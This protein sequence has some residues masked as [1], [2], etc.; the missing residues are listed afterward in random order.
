MD[1]LI[2]Y[3]SQTIKTQNNTPL[4]DFE[5]YSPNEMNLLLHYPLAISC[6]L[7]ML[8]VDNEIY[9]KIPFFNNVKYLLEQIEVQG[10]LK[11]T[12][13][14]FLPTKVVADIYQ[15]GFIK[16]LMIE[17]GYYKLY[18]ESD[19]L[20]VHLT[21]ILTELS[22]LVKKRNN[23]LSLTKKGQT[24]LKN[25]SDLFRNIFETFTVKFNWSYNDGY[26]NEKVGQMGFAFTFILLEKYGQ[27]F[28]SKDFYSEKYLKAFN[29]K[30]ESSDEDQADYS[31]RAY[32]VRTFERFLDYFG[33]IEYETKREDSK[34]K[35]SKLFSDIFKILPHKSI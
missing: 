22:S 4:N 21:R 17:E 33:L 25:N 27:E 7:Q 2:K 31:T 3:I 30:I 11:L 1:D 18:K 19:A 23:K 8:K 28:R 12:A 34:I 6:P 35:A 10:E 24:Q 13:K 26:E 15:Q 20:A 32:K 14:G 5:G 9:T 29:F 16:E